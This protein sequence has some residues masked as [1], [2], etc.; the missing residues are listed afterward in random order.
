MARRLIPLDA[1]FSLPRNLRARHLRHLM[2][3]QLAALLR[4]PVRCPQHGEGRGLRSPRY[5]FFSRADDTATTPLPTEPPEPTAGF[6][7]S[8]KFR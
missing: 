5:G 8:A 2:H 3:Q 6:T 4:T 7:F 1:R